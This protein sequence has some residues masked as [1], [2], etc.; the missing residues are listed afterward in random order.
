MGA[1][2]RL[3]S[4]SNYTISVRCSIFIHYDERQRQTVHKTVSDADRQTRRQVWCNETNKR[5]DKLSI[6]Q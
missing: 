2:G 6:K 1:E 4:F 3:A 5:K